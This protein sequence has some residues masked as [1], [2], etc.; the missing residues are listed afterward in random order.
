[1]EVREKTDLIQGILPEDASK[2]VVSR[3][4]PNQNAFMEVVFSARKLARPRDLRH[5]LKN[6]IKVYLDRIDG[7]AMV[8][9]SGGYEKEI[10]VDVDQTLMSSHGL[11]LL[12]VSG[13]LDTSNV[14][15]PAGHIA[16]GNKDILI[17]TLGEYKTVRDI[18][19]TVLGQNQGGVP[20][21]LSR[22]A[23]VTDSYRDRT[24]LARYN[25]KESVIVSLYRE[26]GKNTVKSAKNAREALASIQSQFSREIDIR[27]VYDE[28]RFIQQSI[29]NITQALVIGGVLAFLALLLI[30]RNLR[31]PLILITVIPISVLTTFIL[32]H[33]RDISLNMMS[34]GGLAIGIGMLFD[35]GNVV[36]AAIERHI[37][38]G[39]Q[40]REAS[41][42][43]ASEVSG[44]ITAAVLTTIIVFL[45]IIFLKGVV[46]VVFAEMA[47]TITFSLSISLL[48]S[49]TLIPMLSSLR[50]VSTGP[51]RLENIGIFQKAARLEAFIE[52]H[53][54]RRLSRV[55]SRPRRP[56]LFLGLLFLLALLASGWVQRE[57]IP[58][59][60]TGEF[61]IELQSTKGTSLESS[62]GVVGLVER[63]LKLDP[64]VEHIMSRVGYDEDDIFARKGGDVGTHRANIRIILKRDRDASTK[65]VSSRIRNQL[66]IRNDISV[67]FIMSGDIL[68]SLLSPNSRA[69]SIELVGS[70]LATLA[71]LGARV[72]KDI[73]RVPGV[74]DVK[75]SMEEKSREYHINFDKMR[76]AQ[77]KLSNDYIS[78]Y[79]KTAVKG[80]IVSR[81]RVADEE[82]DIRL[83][84]KKS[85]RANVN[86]I[87]K[88]LVRTPEGGN[89]YLSQLVNITPKQGFASIIRSGPSRINRI[90]A[91][92]EKVG[93]NEVY[94]NVEDYIS[95]VS[96]PEGYKITFGGEK[97]D[98][99][100]SFKDLIFAFLLA[101]ILIYMLLASQVESLIFPLLM[102]GAIPLVI[103]G[104][105]PALLLTGKSLNVNSI[106]GII[107]LIGIVVDNAV[108][109]FEYVEILRREGRKIKRSV[110]DSGK[111][112][113]APLL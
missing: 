24:G 10:Q 95:R 96:L 20:I 34:L 103:I 49:L 44:S 62:L 21:H 101:L 12:D 18:G 89:V 68:S 59:V 43:G 39:L 29:D 75:S 65:E 80:D 26:A 90:S 35:S 81:L 4:D 93:P 6:E 46:G 22:I 61:S 45:P 84:F 71:E 77:Y 32:M 28:S 36:L 72:K 27:I 74:V 41:L 54:E 15:S 58:K 16:V 98:I 40:P 110:I 83:R 76:M 48:V 86:L 100:N 106:T 55:L 70:D 102:M 97:E 94:A 25:G 88:L 66:K 14:N 2:S 37:R 63:H 13:A 113:F 73:A 111:L 1:M 60:D 9:F 42:K 108:L 50:P 17:R 53:Y 8:R 78:R 107:L 105:I 23:K 11:N 79:L 5:F 92:I 87:K 99:E 67:N 69:L 56:A 82:I 47:M 91:G 112:C 38:T 57:F 52:K 19:Q 33:F 3:F 30:L 64:D 104:I 51:S 7:V 31:S 85:D 109:F